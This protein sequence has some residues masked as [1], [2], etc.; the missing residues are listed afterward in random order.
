MV[1]TP[2]DVVTHIDENI[3]THTY[4]FGSREFGTIYVQLLWQDM[5]LDIEL[6]PQTRERKKGVHGHWE[7]KCN[8]TK[9]MQ[10][11]AWL[12]TMSHVHVFVETLNTSLVGVEH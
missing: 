8:D 1:L 5:R 7:L 6:T 3:N 11:T 2:K 4:V 12:T 10:G 9:I